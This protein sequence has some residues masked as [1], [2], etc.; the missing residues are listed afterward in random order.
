MNK[1]ILLLLLLC[2]LPLKLFAASDSIRLAVISDINSSYGSS[3]Y[4]EHV[5]WA[6][7]RIVQL[8]PD[9][10]LISGDM[11]AGQRTVNLLK[12]M[13][14]TAMW[15]AFDRVVAQPLRKAG[16]PLLAAPGNHDASAEAHFYR[17]RDE[18]KRYWKQH[19][20]ELKAAATNTPLQWAWK[21]GNLT[22]IGLDATRHGPLQP[23]TQKDWLKQ[24]LANNR[25]SANEVVLVSGHLPIWAFANGRETG[26]LADTELEKLL[27]DNRVD[28]YISGHHHAYYPGVHAGLLQ[29]SI[30]A[31][32]SGRRSLIG[33]KKK[34][35]YS[36]LLIDISAGGEMT[37]TALRGKHYLLELE[38]ESLP[39]SIS[40]A[41]VVMK[42]ADLK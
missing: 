42:R 18:F 32:G 39:A 34:S 17:E 6:I 14:I 8:K 15:D 11:V 19:Q 23:V 7:E 3:T 29:I 12:R 33:T 21:L 26:I 13:E 20:P 24:T 41:E 1:N 30:G 31:L 9:L 10:V 4:S 22:I 38:L 25:K 5:R 35:A 36:F 27:H 2:L 16:I 37:Y 28:A 40:S